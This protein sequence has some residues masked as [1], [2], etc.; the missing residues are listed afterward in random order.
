MK[1]FWC[2][3]RGAVCAS[4]CVQGVER[5]GIYGCYIES[6]DYSGVYHSARKMIDGE[7]LDGLPIVADPKVAQLSHDYI[8]AFIDIEEA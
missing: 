4:G 6:D 5:F 7:S 8:L 1:R 3:I 2:N